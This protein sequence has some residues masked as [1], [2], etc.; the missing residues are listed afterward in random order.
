MITRNGGAKGDE[1]KAI[2]AGVF[3]YHEIADV[4]VGKATENAAMEEALSVLKKATKGDA[5]AAQ[6][7]LSEF[8]KSKGINA[9]APTLSEVT[10][11]AL[12]EPS[13]TVA[14]AAEAA[15]ELVEI[16]EIEPT[17]PTAIDE[18]LTVEEN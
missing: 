16:G 7:K 12:E 9:P 13:V 5:A 2:L 8:L 18:T 10:Q 17:E 14:E 11:V 4:E 15:A 3:A 6:A 1:M